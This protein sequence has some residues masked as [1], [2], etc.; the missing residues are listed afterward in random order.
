MHVNNPLRMDALWGFPPRPSASPFAGLRFVASP[1]LVEVVETRV[2]GGY[3]NRW[4]IRA[5]VTRPM[6]H[7]I[8]VGN[9]VLAHPDVIEQIK[10]ELTK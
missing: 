7:G 6:R 10:K 9:T 8:H 1:L 4:L 3:M 5:T 2:P